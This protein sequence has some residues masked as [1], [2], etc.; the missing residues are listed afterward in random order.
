[1]FQKHIIK[2]NGKVSVII[3]YMIYYGTMKVIRPDACGLPLFYDNIIRM[4]TMEIVYFSPA[5]S[6]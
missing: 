1:M 5:W 4:D 2:M 6:I 3:S